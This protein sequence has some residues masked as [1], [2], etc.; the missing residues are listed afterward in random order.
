MN[1][2]TKTLAVLIAAAFATAP[3]LADERENLEMLRQTTLNLIDALVDNGVLP[4]DKADALVR[5][6]EKKAAQ[7]VREKTAAEAKTVRVPYVPESVK[8]EIREQLKQ[9]VLAQAK[10]ERWAE[11]NAVPEWLDRIKWEGD[12]RLRYQSESYARGNTPATDYDP[13]LGYGALTRAADVGATNSFNAYTGNTEAERTRIRLRA[14][15][16]ML[17]RIS[18]SWSAGVRITTGNTSDRVSTNQSLGQNFNKYQ[19]LLDRAYLK[20]DP[21]EW[22]SISGGR[23]PNPWYGMDVIWDEDLNFEGV[24]ATFKPVISADARFRPFITVG[25]FPLRESSPPVAKSRWLYGGQAGAQWNLSHATQLKFGLAYYDFNRLEGAV[26][27]DAEYD[28]VLNSYT[29][30]DYRRFE[31]ESG[32]RQKGNTLFATNAS[33][34][35]NQ[36]TVWGLASKFRPVVVSAGID[37]GR[38]DPV[39]VLLEAEYAKNTAFDREEIFRRTG[40]QL[41]DGK[42]S[43]YQVRLTVGMPQLKAAHDWQVYGGYRYLGSDSVVD[44]FTDSDFGLGGTNLKGYFIGLRYGVDRNAFLNVRLM[45]ADT[46]YTPTLIDPDHKFGVDVLQADVNVRF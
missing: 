8:K 39:H 15:L 7:T 12:I 23:I 37:F 31:Y 3:A 32:L 17:A 43:A 46:I 11:P 20:F 14:R 34:D 35:F 6:A 41:T 24:A 21:A 29:T 16:G 27:P 5:A 26:I 18:E 36:K 44:A 40:Y 33:T 2:R 30:A 4:K 45:S 1:N 13:S 10:S 19:L 9:E 25:A 22:L 38:F 42:S 28:N